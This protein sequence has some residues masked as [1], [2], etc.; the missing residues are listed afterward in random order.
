MAVRISK[1][2]LHHAAAPGESRDDFDDC[3][4]F[5]GME[6]ID[7]PDLLENL[8]LLQIVRHLWNLR[9][10]CSIIVEWYGLNYSTTNLTLHFSRYYFN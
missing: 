8:T 4:D 1:Q 3:Y 10:D 6:E 9:I 5:V 2:N 7:F